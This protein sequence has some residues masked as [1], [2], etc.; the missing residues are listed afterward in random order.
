MQYSVLERV[1]DFIVQPEGEM[2]LIFDVLSDIQ[3]RTVT[4]LV[5][6]GNSILKGFFSFLM[7][8]NDV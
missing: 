4:H 3:T 2:E 7:S 5:Y 8:R 6:Q 1:G